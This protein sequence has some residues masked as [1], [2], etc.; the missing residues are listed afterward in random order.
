[1]SCSQH[2][3]VPPR[4][5]QDLRH[6]HGARAGEQRVPQHAQRHGHV[7]LEVRPAGASWRG[8]A[9]LERWGRGAV[10]LS[11]VAGQCC[12]AMR[13]GL[14]SAA[15]WQQGLP[16]CP[17]LCAPCLLECTLTPLSAI[18]GES[19]PSGGAVRHKML[20][21]CAAAC[22]ATRPAARRRCCLGGAAPRRSTS[23]PLAL[24]SGRSARVSALG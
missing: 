13:A 14:G 21:R 17:A 10:L 19:L 9:A 2:P 3:A 23:T 12:W 24:S 8:C 4:Y 15:I 22:R 18:T 6:R 7:R 16:G 5:R 20:T 1:M 11:A